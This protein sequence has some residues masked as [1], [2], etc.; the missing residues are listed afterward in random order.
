MIRQ[1]EA[2]ENCDGDNY[3]IPGYIHTVIYTR[4]YSHSL[5]GKQSQVIRGLTAVG[6]PRSAQDNSDMNET[7][8]ESQGIHPTAIIDP[9]ARLGQGVSVGPYSVIGP[10]VVIGDG[11]VIQNHVTITGP[12]TIGVENVIYPYASVGHDPQ[13]KKFKSSETSI[14]EIGDR[15]RIRECVTINRGTE[16]GGG[17]TRVGN[18]NWIMAYVHIAHD[19]I[20]GNDTVLANATLGGHVTVEDRAYLGGFTAAH[21]FCRIGR[22]VMTGGHTMIAQDVPPYVVAVGNR[23]KMF[24]INK[25]GLERY[26]FTK[27]EIKGVEKAYKMFTRGRGKTEDTL[28]EIEQALGEIEPVR[29]FVEFI[30]KSERGVCR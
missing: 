7:N 27:E 14:L 24:G 6:R 21:Q 30:R 16:D 13:D 11:T 1:R 10:D 4:L 2:R 17:Y 5:Q 25:V 9:G 26:G 19:C 22:H 18:D 15:N 3:N 12:T 8:K 20:V 28:S 23:A 29:N